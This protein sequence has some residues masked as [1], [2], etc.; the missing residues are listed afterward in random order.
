MKYK[1][2]EIYPSKEELL[3]GFKE[4]KKNIQ[5]QRGLS[6][7]QSLGKKAKKKRHEK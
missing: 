1:E 2:Q 5:I 6:A 7:V 3:E 4:I